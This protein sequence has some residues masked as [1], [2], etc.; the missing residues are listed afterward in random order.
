[1]SIT[2]PISFTTQ[3]SITTPISFTTQMSTA[4]QVPLFSRHFCV[5]VSCTRRLSFT[6]H[7][8]LTRNLSFT[9][10][11]FVVYST[12]V[13]YD[14]GWKLHITIPT[15]LSHDWYQNTTF[16]IPAC[17]RSFFCNNKNTRNTLKNN[18][19]RGKT[20]QTL[21]HAFI[22]ER[23]TRMTRAKLGHL[24]PGIPVGIYFSLSALEHIRSTTVYY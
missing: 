3:M 2:R 20:E 11:L 22:S 21:P 10:H 8:S 7:L 24:L 13:V 16:Q 14:I 4:T 9:Q 6:R 15:R 5:G 19:R 1:M 12:S 18:R 23:G 17:M